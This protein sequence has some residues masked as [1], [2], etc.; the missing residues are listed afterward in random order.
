MFFQPILR[1]PGSAAPGEATTTTL[2]N[3]TSLGFPLPARG[4]D[5]ST[6]PADICH[7]GEKR[8]DSSPGIPPT[9]K[10]PPTTLDGAEGTYPGW[11]INPSKSQRGGNIP[12]QPLLPILSFPKATLISSNTLSTGTPGVSC[13]PLLSNM[14]YFAGQIIRPLILWLPL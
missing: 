2:V 4:C 13:V 14:I 9:A 8:V 10:I 3:Q 6:S 7:P 11:K 1:L 12:A 5:T